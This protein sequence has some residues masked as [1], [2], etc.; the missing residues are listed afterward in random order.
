MPRRG[1]CTSVPRRVSDPSRGGPANGAAYPAAGVGDFRS[2]RES[3]ED[4][5]RNAFDYG[6][7][8]QALHR[9]RYLQAEHL[10]DN[11]A[12]GAPDLVRD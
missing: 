12:L 7:E 11:S 10:I 3:G 9:D 4:Y 2:D 8:S 5:Y 6:S 1:L